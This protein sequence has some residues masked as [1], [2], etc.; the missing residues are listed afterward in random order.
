MARESLHSTTLRRD[1]RDSQTVTGQCNSL[2]N[3]LQPRCN[4][5]NVQTL[6]AF[7]I[8]SFDT[9]LY[10]RDES[11]ENIQSQ[12]SNGCNGDDCEDPSYACSNPVSETFTIFLDAGPYF[13]ILQ[14][15][16]EGGEYAVEIQCA[17]VA[18]PAP[19]IST[20]STTIDLSSEADINCDTPLTRAIEDGG[21][22][23]LAFNNSV[24]GWRRFTNCDADVDLYMFLLDESGNEIQSQATNGCDGEDCWDP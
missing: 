19:T 15:Y 21:N 23:L 3:I 4:V 13:L 22:V 12:A 9:K 14:P 11:G 24:A 7:T 18:S 2:H 20:T 16:E 17:N 6:F 5:L 10:L 1:G 8:S